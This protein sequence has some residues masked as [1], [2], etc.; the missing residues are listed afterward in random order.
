MLMSKIDTRDTGHYVD[1][2]KR[3]GYCIIPSAMPQSCVTSLA[4][5]L[6]STFSQTL[7]SQG[8]FY[9]ADTKRF[10]GLLARSSHAAAFVQNRLVLDIVDQILS[11]WCD[12]FAL[13]LTQAIEI[14]PD[15]PDQVP[16]RDQ[17]M[18]PASRLIDASLRVEFLVNVMWPFTPYTREN[19]ATRIWPGSHNRQSEALLDPKDAI[20]AEMNA[21]S[22]LIFLGSTLH[23]GGANRSRYSRRGMIVSYCLG[24]LKPYELQ[25]LVYP[26]EIARTFSGALATLVGY[27][28]HRPNLGNVEGRC[29]SALL[30]DTNTGPA[31]AIDCLGA[32]QE[33]IISD[34]LH[35]Q[36]NV[37]NKLTRPI[38]RTA[39][40]A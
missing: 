7:R 2:L 23:G 10:G 31:G 38:R 1:R 40:P 30:S 29:P 8:A 33:K 4:G 28:I 37:D 13:N 15:A 6:D 9:G 32:E 27:R 25:W 24:W 11:P 14:L 16:H 39:R 3:E 5:D 20:A 22:A 26:P 18:W 34:Y 12:R 21:G 36:E 17:D 35:G 19:G